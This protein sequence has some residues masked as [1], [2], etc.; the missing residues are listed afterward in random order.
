MSLS[1]TPSK[2]MYHRYDSGKPWEWVDL[3]F[4][5]MPVLSI[6]PEPG[7]NYQ[8]KI[9]VLEDGNIVFGL[10]PTGFCMFTLTIVGGTTEH[11]GTISVST[12]WVHSDYMASSVSLVVEIKSVK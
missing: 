12:D 4:N 2:V 6:T 1:F 7:C 10:D 3:H 11:P 5:H 8:C 9:T